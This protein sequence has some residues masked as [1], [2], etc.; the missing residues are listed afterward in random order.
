MTPGGDALAD[1]R[2]RPLMKAKLKKLLGSLQICR[3]FERTCWQPCG[4]KRTFSDQ[5]KQRPLVGASR[6]ESSLKEAA[7]K[8]QSAI[9]SENSTSLQ[10]EQ[11]SSH[12]TFNVSSESME[13]IDKGKQSHKYS[14]HDGIHYPTV[15]VGSFLSNIIFLALFSPYMKV[16]NC[17]NNNI[18]DHNPVW[19]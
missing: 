12:N 14:T 8:N 17:N 10:Q 16:I 15:A 4:R 19:Q 5:E 9:L 6:K 13:F 2:T 11:P 18:N 7:S 3:E 1:G